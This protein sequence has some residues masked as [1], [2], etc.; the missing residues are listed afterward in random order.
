MPSCLPDIVMRLLL[1]LQPSACTAA[2]RPSA[3]PL[4]SAGNGSG[5]HGLQCGLIYRGPAHQMCMSRSI[6]GLSSWPLPAAWA[7]TYGLVFGLIAASITTVC[8][9]SFL[10]HTG[11]L[12]LLASLLLYCAAELGFALLVR[13]RP[14]CCSVL[15]SASLM[16]GNVTA[17][18][19]W[20]TSGCSIPKHLS[21]SKRRAPHAWCSR[22]HAESK[23]CRWRPASP[24]P[25]RRHCVRPSCTSAPSCP[26]ISSSGQAG[27]PI[28]S[29]TSSQSAW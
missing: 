18:L 24:V 19:Q 16:V 17:A 22:V 14:C 3:H 9:A 10:S 23:S 29:A 8:C 28:A 15:L 11:F 4:A 25:R 21:V 1:L 2:S 13:D 7:T 5:S 6:M 20:C 27:P 12:L 26:D